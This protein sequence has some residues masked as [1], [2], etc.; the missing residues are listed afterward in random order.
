MTLFISIVSHQN[1]EE[2]IEQLRPH[3]LAGEQTHIVLLDNLPESRLADYCAEN[4]LSYLANDR[5]S[6]FGSNHNRAFSYCREHLELKPE[7]DWFVVLN[8]DVH[9]TRDAIDQLLTDLKNYNPAI[10]APNLFRDPQF[11]L[12]EGSVR[13]FPYLWDFIASFLLKSNRTTVK[14]R[15]ITSPCPV[16]WAS[17]A[18]LVFKA[19]I[20]QDLGGFDERYFLYC[21]DVDICWRALK[22]KGIKPIYLPEVKAVHEGKRE[23]HKTISRYLWWHISSAFRFSW[24]RLKTKLFGPKALKRPPL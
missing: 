7:S 17:G 24:V 19:K 1:A 10:A 9:V 8:P 23:S 22:L 5:P 16:D 3:E 13:N 21:E 12:L 15:H 14:R 6:G 20:F 4:G 11:Q 18:F 2:I